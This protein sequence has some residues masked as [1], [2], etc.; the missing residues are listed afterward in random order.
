MLNSLPLFIGL[1]YVRARS[2]KFF[3][4]FITWVSLLCVCLGVAA[5]IVILSAMN[6]LEG[7]LRSRLLSLSAHARVYVAPDAHHAQQPKATTPDWD[8]LATHLRS[9]PAVTGTTPFIELEALAVRKPDMLP[10]RLRGIDP[11]HEGEVGKLTAA[12]AEGRL[13]DLEPGSDRVLLGRNM[14]VMLG[15]ALGDAIT[16]LVPTTD[17]NGV[18]EPR[19]REFTVAGVFNTEVPEYD[20]LL[21][22]SLDDVRALLP[23]PDARMSLQVNFTDALLA[24][25]AS[26]AI[27]KSLPAGVEIRDWTADHA[28]YFRAIR[29]EKTMVAIIL[30]LIVA[31]A[32]F[33]LVAMLAMVVT[34]KRTDI[35]IL[36]TLG[37]SPRQVMAVFLIQGGVIAWFGVALGVGLGSL[38]GHN[39]GAVAA[40]FERLFSFEIFNSEVYTVTRIPSELHADQ[41]L[42]VA[43]IA[44]LITLAATIYPA[45]RASRV[46]PADALRYE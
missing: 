9:Q 10:V 1:R 25:E 45:F 20:S 19:L 17:A 21:I 22:A 36:R 34:D 5:L 29:L 4:S 18:P 26:A 11:A 38:V 2:H 15:L 7:E 41:I 46:P 40:F 37:T 6:G 23:N 43:G 33:Y 16:V 27:A 39:A 8:E 32:A 31:V 12:L 24:P 28:S 3:V 35:A 30:M 14:A 42:W 44:M 13:S